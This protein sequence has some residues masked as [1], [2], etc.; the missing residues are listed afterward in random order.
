MS[1]LSDLQTGSA[2]LQFETGVE[3]AAGTRV[4]GGLSYLSASLV[5]ET[6]IAAHL[7]AEGYRL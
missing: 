4:L 1:N 2:P 5:F 6:P 7:L 3:N